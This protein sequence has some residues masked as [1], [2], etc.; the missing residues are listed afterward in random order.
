MRKKNGTII[1]HTKPK[2]RQKK[3]FNYD[4]ENPLPDCR[5]QP[6]MTSRNITTTSQTR[7]LFEHFEIQDTTWLLGINQH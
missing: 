4:V 2:V 7:A 5:A 1:K 3:S 6:L